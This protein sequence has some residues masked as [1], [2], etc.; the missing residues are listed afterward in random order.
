MAT[1]SIQDPFI[2]HVLQGYRIDKQQI[3]VSAELREFVEYLIAQ[4]LIPVKQI[5]SYVLA[6]EF[7]ALY[8]Q[9]AY[10]GKS[11]TVRILSQRYG[12]S[13]STIWNLLKQRQTAS[14]LAEG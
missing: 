3:P 9:G 6:Q 10:R 11:E 7:D 13:E 12:V 4:N 5:R 2:F 1:H 14:A 8:R